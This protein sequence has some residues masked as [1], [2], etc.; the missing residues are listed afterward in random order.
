MVY[1]IN[2]IDR[3]CYHPYCKELGIDVLR[4]SKNIYCCFCK[5][6][7]PIY[8]SLKGWTYNWEES[9]LYKKSIIQEIHLLSDKEAL[10]AI[11]KKFH[12]NRFIDGTLHRQVQRDSDIEEFA[13]HC[14]IL[15]SKEDG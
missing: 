14:N 2:M 3:R 9:Q 13:T 4:D 5:E 15:R 8:K 10:T 6:H 7:F 12:I 1:N 11:E